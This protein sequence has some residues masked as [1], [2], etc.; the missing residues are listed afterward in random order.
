[1][2]KVVWKMKKIQSLDCNSHLSWIKLHGVGGVFL[3]LT[4]LFIAIYSLLLLWTICQFWRNIYHLMIHHLQKLKSIYEAFSLR[5]SFFTLNYFICIQ[6]LTPNCQGVLFFGRCANF[7][8]FSHLLY[9]FTQ[10]WVFTL[11]FM[12]S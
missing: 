6:G 8:H 2:L 9:T 1:M 10:W 3:F 11:N 12:G 4:S 5:Q 7:I